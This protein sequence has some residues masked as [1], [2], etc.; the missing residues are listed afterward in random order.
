MNFSKAVLGRRRK[1]VA[2]EEC[3]KKGAHK[4][5]KSPNVR[6]HLKPFHSKYGELN[7]IAHP[8]LT[9]IALGLTRFEENKAL[10]PTTTPEFNKKVW[11]Q[12]LRLRHPIA[13]K[14]LL[15]KWMKPFGMH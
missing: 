15:G 8:A 6:I 7:D 12:F 9:E 13:V 4:E 10:G 5:G 2:L 3:L 14:K 11:P 1:F